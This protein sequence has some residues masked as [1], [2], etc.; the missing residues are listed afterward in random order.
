[1]VFIA[2]G[3]RMDL[4]KTFLK[5]LCAIKKPC[6]FAPASEERQ[7]GDGG[8]RGDLDLE[9]KKKDIKKFGFGDWLFVSLQPQM[10][11]IS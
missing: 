2:A 3:V 7:C 6:T 11:E 4:Q 10:R 9:L 1:V 5:I 8:L